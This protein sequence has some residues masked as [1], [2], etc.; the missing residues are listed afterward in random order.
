MESR[1]SP[2]TWFNIK[3]SPYQYRKSHC[4]DKTV[5]RL[6]CLCNGISYTGKMT[7]LYWIRALAAFPNLCVTKPPKL[8]ITGFLC[9]QAA[10]Q[11]I[12]ISHHWLCVTKPLDQRLCHTHES[13][14]CDVKFRLFSALCLYT[15]ISSNSHSAEEIKMG[16]SIMDTYN[17]HALIYSEIFSK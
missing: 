2:G 11:A 7:S 4:G 9:D 14:I 5:V 1:Q 6:S 17:G 12:H 16:V 3:M 8:H 15:S 13:V 10:G